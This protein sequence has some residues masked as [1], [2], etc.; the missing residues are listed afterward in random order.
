MLLCER[1]IDC[2][3][4]QIL[5]GGIELTLAGGA[6]TGCESTM[7]R[8]LFDR[9]CEDAVQKL[10]KA[11]PQK[12]PGEIVQSSEDRQKSGQVLAILGQLPIRISKMPA[13]AA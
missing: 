7:G 6:V 12:Q 2:D 3:P 8:L 1:S 4:N 11:S 10:L 13:R 5:T 9:S